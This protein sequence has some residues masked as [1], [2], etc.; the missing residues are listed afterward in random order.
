MDT[1]AQHHEL[2]STPKQ[3]RGFIENGNWVTSQ[4]L[5]HCLSRIRA[6]IAAAVKKFEKKKS[7]DPTGETDQ[8][9]DQVSKR[10]FQ[11]LQASHCFLQEKVESLCRTVES[12]QQFQEAQEERAPDPGRVTS[13]KAIR[14]TRVERLFTDA[15]LLQGQSLTADQAK[16]VVLFQ[17]LLDTGFVR[18]AAGALSIG[19]AEPSQQEDADDFA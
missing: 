17:E 6:E 2:D 15:M 9:T 18:F 19:L 16:S 13:V 4:F 11:D 1:D 14:R 7:A 3:I 5:Q 8:G 10:E 12:V